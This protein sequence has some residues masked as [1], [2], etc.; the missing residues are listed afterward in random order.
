MKGTKLLAL[1]MVFAMMLALAGC[2][3][4]ITID[5]VELEFRP[6]AL[7]AVAEKA[8]ERKIGARGLRAVLESLM[9][10]IMFEIPSDKTITK[11][12]VT[13]DCVRNGTQPEVVRKSDPK[14]RSHVS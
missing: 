11:V 13:E 6:E 12:I 3:V 2:T 5:G 7:E 1:V 10:G 9:T 4:E 8:I 14:D